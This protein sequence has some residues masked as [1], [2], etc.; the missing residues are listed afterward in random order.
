MLDSLKCTIQNAHS[1]SES[2]VTSF[3]DMSPEES[4]AVFDYTSVTDRAIY[5]PAETFTRNIMELYQ[6]C[7]VSLLFLMRQPYLHQPL[8]QL[9]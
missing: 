5:M 8:Q 4:V 2:V 1:G 9:L 6:D 7:H 3:S